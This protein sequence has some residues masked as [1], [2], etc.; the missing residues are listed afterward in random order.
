M[1]AKA[2]RR[3]T[4]VCAAVAAGIGMAVTATAAFHPAVLAHYA[5]SVDSVGIAQWAEK[6][7]ASDVLRWWTGTWIQADSYYYRPLASMLFW[8]EHL[9]FGYN[10][11]GHVLISWLLHA[12][13]CVCI[14]A[15]TLR[16]YPGQRRI[17]LVTGLLAVLLANLRLTPEGPH[18][19]VGPVASAVVA[20]WPAQT[21]QASLLL[22]LLAL[23]ALDRWLQSE[24]GRGLAKA[25]GLWLA[26]VLFKEMAVVLPLLAGLLILMRRGLQALRVF[27][28]DE[29]GALRLSPGL[30]WR[31]VLPAIAAMAL[32]V[33]A[34]PLIVPGAWGVEREP[35]AFYLHK[36]I[37]LLFPRPWMIL[38]SQG[39]WGPIA[40]VFTAL[41]VVV[42]VRLRTRPCVI[43]LILA[44]VVGNGLIAQLA[45]GSFALLTFLGQLA[46]LGT[47]TLLALGLIVLAHVR[48][49][50]VWGVLGMAL[51]V[52]LPLLHVWGP[53]YFYWP[54]AFWGLLNAG[55]WH[56]AWLRHREGTLR[57]SPA[58]RHEPEAGTD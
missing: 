17:A 42:Y 44:L 4:I 6:A 10:F 5:D 7:D 37:F 45:G 32:F 29:K 38:V 24:D 55:L 34:R 16:L 19:E 49:G 28:R 30:V 57:W 58:A 13:V 43:W 40:A 56:W 20:W 2:S 54:A 12:G 35:M 14:F 15:L 39:V 31:I 41:T 52:H 25:G 8:A 46:N 22:S 21:D 53:H 23:L 3:A 33:A 36:V 26:G 27:E 9:L 51:V 47:L 50:W 11:Q 48:E 18:W 1:S